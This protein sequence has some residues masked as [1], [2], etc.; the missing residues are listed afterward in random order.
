M[1]KEK[2]PTYMIRTEIEVCVPRPINYLTVAGI[3]DQ[4]IDVGTLSDEEAERWGN[5][6]KDTFIANVKQRRK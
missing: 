3:G 1:A 2:L 4:S 6:I 5:I